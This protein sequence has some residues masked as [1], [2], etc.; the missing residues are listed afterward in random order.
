M[1]GAFFLSVV[2]GQRAAILELLAGQDQTLLIWRNA[3]FVM[4]CWP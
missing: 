2:V 3:F 1:Q 4:N